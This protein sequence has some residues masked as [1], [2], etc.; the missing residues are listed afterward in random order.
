MHGFVH[1]ELAHPG[2]GLF[3]IGQGVLLGLPAQ[4]LDPVVGPLGGA[5]DRPGRAGLPALAHEAVGH[6]GVQIGVEGLG[7]RA[8]RLLRGRAVV[9]GLEVVEVGAQVFLSLEAEEKHA[10]LKLDGRDAGLIGGGNGEDQPLVTRH[11]R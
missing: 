4:V 9:V 1:A 7:E 5:E 11:L 6:E 2:H 3:Q 8:F 10:L